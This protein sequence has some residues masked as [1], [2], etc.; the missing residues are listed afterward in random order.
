MK[1]NKQDQESFRSLATSIHN[2]WRRR[3][4]VYLPTLKGQKLIIKSNKIPATVEDVINILWQNENLKPLIH[5]KEFNKEKGKW[6]FVI[7]LP[8]G[9]SFREFSNSEEYFKDATRRPTLIE[10]KGGV[11]VLQ[12]LNEPLKHGKDYKFTFNPQDY[13]KMYL[14]IVLGYSVNGLLV[15]DFGEFLYLLIGG[16]PKG[17]KSTLI[18][19][20][21]TSLLLS[22][23]D[24]CF[25]VVIDFKKAEYAPYMQKRG[26]LVTDELA[27]HNVL[28]QLNNELDKRNTFLASR[29]KVKI[30]NL[31]S[32]QRPPF[33]VVVVDELTELQ[34]K[35]SQEL[36][37]RLARLGRSPGFCLILAT[38]RPSAKAF[39]D[40][41]FTETRALCDARLCFRVKS[42]RDSE[43][44]LNNPKG[45]T[46][47]AIPG[48]GIFQWDS[49]LE[50]QV[51][52]IDPEKDVEQILQDGGVFPIERTNIFHQSNQEPPSK[53]LN[54]RQSYFGTN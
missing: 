42:G 12:I 38:Q 24:N 7:H 16:I 51:P 41:T 26:L 48:R 15:K 44:I 45:F 33:I 36:L 27:T 40:G 2:L 13:P 39:R 49:E 9:I 17:G 54:A 4:N 25:I 30:H 22:R 53:M 50:I 5:K 37:N 20:I 11:P 1:N 52:F 32:N 34:N 6:N 35:K 29:N 8:P 31:H 19:V 18:H 3:D 10:N 14:P 46:I 23:N 28:Q 43:M 47:P 21:L